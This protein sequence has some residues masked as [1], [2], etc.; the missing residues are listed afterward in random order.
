MNNAVKRLG[1]PVF[2]F[3]VLLIP[4]LFWDTLILQVSDDLIRRSIVIGRYVIGTCLWLTLAWFVTRF[5]DV[6]VW[7]VLNKHRLGYPIP[8]LLIVFV[9]L[10]IVLVAIGVIISEVFE[11]SV[12]GLFAASGVLGVVLGVAVRDMIADFFSGIALILERSFAVG[13]RVQIEGTELTGDIV[14]INWRTTVIKTVS[15]N[16]M[17]I[18][19]SR[20]A[21]LR[22]TKM[23]VVVPS[24]RVSPLPA[25][26]AK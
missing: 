18:P 7:S 10:I 9:R 20:M 2:F 14:E 4:A 8:Q 1:V 3:V 12:T 5:L 16:H 19:N 22:V 23:S 21:R 6:A 25:K 26:R 17:I 24:T 13:D 11:K 15:G